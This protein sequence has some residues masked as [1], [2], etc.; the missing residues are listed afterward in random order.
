[1]WQRQIESI[2]DFPVKL[3]KGMYIDTRRRRHCRVRGSDAPDG[4]IPADVAMTRCVAIFGLLATLLAA[5]ALA[6]LQP[7]D[8]AP[9]FTAQAS[10]AGRVF[11]I[12]LAEALKKGPVVLYF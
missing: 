8:L 4:Q 12:S 3:Q 9:E 11:T 6:A 2:P 5:P 10:L 7:G 1:M